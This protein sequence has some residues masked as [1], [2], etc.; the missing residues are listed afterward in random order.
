[1][2]SA[3]LED[4]G[5]LE[6]AVARTAL[7]ACLERV[8]SAS[9]T[10]PPGVNGPSLVKS[11]LAIMLSQRLACDLGESLEAAA[12]GW[13]QYRQGLAR[14]AKELQDAAAM[15][16]NPPEAGQWQGLAGWLWVTRV[17]EGVWQRFQE[18]GA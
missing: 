5:G 9:P 15:T 18:N 10:P 12:P 17:L 7:A 1:L 6:A 14:L 8:L 3:W 2:I 13:P 16:D 4:Q 11:F